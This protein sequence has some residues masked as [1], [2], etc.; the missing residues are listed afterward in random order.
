MP[1]KTYIPDT[2]HIIELHFEHS[3]GA[4]GSDRKPAL[5]LSPAAYNQRTGLV[6]SC[7]ITSDIKGYP[8]EV[9]LKNSTMAVLADQI[10]SLDWKNTKISHAGKVQTKELA[11]VRSKLDVLLFA[12]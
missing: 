8:F 7:A 10:K 2:G 12:S 9:A 1:K 6:I 3:P 5:V 11:E 4:F